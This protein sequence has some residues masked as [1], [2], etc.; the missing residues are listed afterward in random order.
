MSGARQPAWRRAAHRGR[1]PS[2]ILDAVV[3]STDATPPTWVRRIR[4]GA[5]ALVAFVL[6]MFE[7]VFAGSLQLRGV[8]L[9]AALAGLVVALAL[10]ALWLRQRPGSLLAG[11]T[12]WTGLALAFAGTLVAVVQPRWAAPATLAAAA[13]TAATLLIPARQDALRLLAG[14]AFVATGVALA[15]PGV[16]G[17]ATSADVPL[18]V[19]RLCFGVGAAAIGLAL[20]AD[21]DA[22]LATA[23]LGVGLMITGLGL[24]IVFN[25]HLLLGLTV[26]LVGLAGTA[27]LLAFL[28][29]REVLVGLTLVA[30]APGM[31]GWGVAHIAIDDV[32]VGAALI[33]L[34][35]ML[36][37]SGVAVIARRDLL[38]R[39]ALVGAGL[40]VA[41]AGLANIGNGDVLL[42]M[43]GVGSGA[44]IAARIGRTLTEGST[45]DGLRGWWRHITED[46]RA[47]V[48]A[49]AA[50]SEGLADAAPPVPARPAPAG[51]PRPRPARPATRRSRRRRR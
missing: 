17:L 26:T 20:I 24:L 45:G 16:A 5:V 41:G 48:P 11:A 43:G 7:D 1:R 19:A 50:S 34:A 36:A 9:V 13:V 51:V 4:Q 39:V 21:L 35:V 8:A 33:V 6:G 25:G 3:N 40:A 47:A 12:L 44:A 42:G 27:A 38:S 31:A 22:L 10:A 18:S 49:D 2:T 14:A 37:V 46:R 32:L 29:R 15:A 30:G 23:G 28:A